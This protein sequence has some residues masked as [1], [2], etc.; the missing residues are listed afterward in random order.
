LAK[1]KVASES[2]LKRATL[3]AIR[4]AAQ[5]AELKV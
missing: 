5:Y 2:Q 4:E 3:A 1:Y